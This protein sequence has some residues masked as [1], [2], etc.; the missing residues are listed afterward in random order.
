MHGECQGGNALPMGPD[1]SSRARLSGAPQAL[2]QEHH[3]ET[4]MTGPSAFRF[5]DPGNSVCVGALLGLWAAGAHAQTPA[6]QM[7]TVYECAPPYSF[8]FL[9]CTGSSANDTCDVQSF[10]AGHPFQRGKSTYPQVTGMLSH[11]HLQTPAEAQADAR[12]S[13]VPLPNPGGAGPGGFKVGDRVRILSDGWQE[14]Q[15]IQIH[16]ASYVVHLSNGVEVSKLWPIEVRRIGPLTAEDHAAG[17]YDKGDRVQVLV[18]GRWMPGEI[19][20]QNLNMYNILVPGVD[21]GFGDN[22][23]GYD[24]REHPHVHPAPRRPSP[25]RARPG[26]FRSPDLRAAPAGMRGRWE[27]AGGMAGMEVIFRS[28][29]A[30]HQRRTGRPDAL[31]LLH[32]RRKNGVLQGRFFPTVRL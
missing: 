17:Q 11:C 27:L 12:N 18:N 29:T 4:G 21:T 31:R 8:K 23:V 5:R 10:L 15:I 2:T 14:A 32:G 1:I 20:G 25:H 22:H 7:N 16:G 6:L 30:I 13:A 9:S 26:R 3:E 19:R 28:G 24:T